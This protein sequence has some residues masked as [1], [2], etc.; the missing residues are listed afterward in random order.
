MLKISLKSARVNAGYTQKEVAT[1][2]GISNKTL[3][4]WENFMSY[5]TVDKVDAL[6]KLYGVQ[7]NDIIFLPDGS[8][9]ANEDKCE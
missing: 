6:C 3:N 5:P 8:L 7:Y 9:L 2:L 1:K 4:G